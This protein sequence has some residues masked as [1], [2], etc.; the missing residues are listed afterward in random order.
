MTSSDNDSSGEIST[1]GEYNMSAS[2]VVGTQR[3]SSMLE[4]PIE[5]SAYL[6]LPYCAFDA[7]GIP[8]H[9]NSY[10]YHPT[11][12]THYAL[13]YWNLYLA[14]HEEHYLNIFLKQAGWLVEHEVVIDEETS[15]WPHS[16]SHPDVS[17]KGS[18]LS[19]LT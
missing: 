5:M 18:W 19:A 9:V 6:T 11:T 2:G 10:S 16:F 1:R 3:I 12:I 8:Y 17:T 7:A 13:A 14:T 4:Y 15:G